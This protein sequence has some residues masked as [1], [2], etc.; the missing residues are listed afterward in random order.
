MARAGSGR[1]GARNLPDNSSAKCAASQNDPPLPQLNARPPAQKASASSVPAA[2]M[3]SSVAVSAIRRARASDAWVSAA[4]TCDIRTFY[5]GAQGRPARGARRSVKIVRL[6]R[7]PGAAKRLDTLHLDRDDA[8]LILE[9][10]LD[11]QIRRLHNRALARGEHG[12]LDDE[13]RYPRFVLDRQEHESLGGARPLAGND[14]AGHAH[15]PPGTAA[16]QIH[17]PRDA[18]GRQRWTDERHRM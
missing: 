17:R 12:G 6:D 4:V 5:R 3:R 7:R 2:S 11:E 9:N 14:G 15:A 8:R 10:A 16:R 1:R 13:V 18:A